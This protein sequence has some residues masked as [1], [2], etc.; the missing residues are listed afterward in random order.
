MN[1]VRVYTALGFVAVGPVVTGHGIAF[2]PMQRS[3]T[4]HDA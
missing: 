4:E 2:Q 1:A 3:A